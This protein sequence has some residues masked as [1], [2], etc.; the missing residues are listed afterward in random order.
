MIDLRAFR[1]ALQF[2]TRLPIRVDFAVDDAT[3]GRSILFYP[4]VGAV[5][6]GLLWSVVSMLPDSTPTLASVLVLT[7][8]VLLTGGLHLDGLADCAD[9][10]IGGYG[11]RERSF[12]IMKDPASGPIAVVVLVLT[13]MLKATALS[14]LMERPQGWPLLMTPILGR[15]AILALML[16][17]PY[18]NPKGLAAGMMAHLSRPTARSVLIASVV[19]GVF[20]LGVMPMVIAAVVLM[21]V[22]AA[23]LQRLGGA[24]GDV[25]GAAVELTE[26]A[27]L[28]TLAL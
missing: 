3:A 19:L 14:A 7:I 16:S 28:V 10:W 13:L 21:L 1:L 9:A 24:T 26:T 18:V 20:T 6:G 5:I 4:A 11:N 15:S 23:A 2:L 8:W 17:M 25:Y 27:L 12:E 22:R